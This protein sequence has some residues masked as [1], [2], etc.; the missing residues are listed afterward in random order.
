MLYI[1]GDG[2]QRANIENYIENNNLSKKVKLL[3]VKK[4]IYEILNP[5][6]IIFQ[7]P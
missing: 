6:W 1:I 5:N 4:N 3:G 2:D 7:P